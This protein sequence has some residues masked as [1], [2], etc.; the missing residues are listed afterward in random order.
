MQWKDSTTGIMDVDPLL[1]AEPLPEEDAKP[2]QEE[3][4][5]FQ[6]HVNP[7]GDVTSLEEEVMQRR[8]VTA[9]QLRE[10]AKPARAVKTLEEDAKPVEEDGK[11]VLEEV[12]QRK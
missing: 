7:V 3:G 8:E 1:L 5:P 9:L 6:E 10:D 11:P 12:S 4:A 2:I